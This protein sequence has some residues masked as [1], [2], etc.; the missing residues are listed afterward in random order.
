[1][2]WMKQILIEYSEL[3]PEITSRY[4]G[5]AAVQPG[6]DFA[7]VLDQPNI[8]FIC[9]TKKAS[10]QIFITKLSK[11]LNERF[12]VVVFS[13]EKQLRYPAKMEAKSSLRPSNLNSNGTLAL[14]KA[15]ITINKF[16]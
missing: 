5:T 1:M 6:I 10:F 9:S 14:G 13:T 7:K 16:L 11:T 8:L 4:L 3:G 15:E 12:K 2:D